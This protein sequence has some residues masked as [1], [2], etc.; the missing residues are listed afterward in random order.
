M[1]YETF[2][3]KFNE[4][5]TSEKIT[6]FNN[7]C[8]EYGDSDKMIYSFD[9]EFFN[10]AFSNPMDAAR[11][12]YFGSIENWSDEYICFNG[13]G[14]LESLSEYDVDG[15]IEY[16]LDEIFD[17]EKTWEEYIEDD[18]EEDN[19]DGE[20][21]C[22]NCGHVFKQG[23]YNYNYD[24]ALLDFVCPDCDWEGNEKQVVWNTDEEE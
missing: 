23:E 2:V 20:Y 24:T 4:L 11:A 14:N 21:I 8:L 1:K 10:M 3:E 15:E 19:E 6:I 18:G 7:Y 12:V 17:H 16:Y 9:E 22:P 13:Y 5:S